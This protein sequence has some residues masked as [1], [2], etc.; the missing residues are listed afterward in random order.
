MSLHQPSRRT[1]LRGAALWAAVTAAGFGPVK[2]ALA[3]PVF[4]ND[5]FQL[6][7]ASG[8]PV[9]D[10]FVI[11]TRLAPDPFDPQALPDEAIPVAW[12][13]A[14]DAAMKKI[15]ASGQVYARPDMAHSVHVDVRGLEPHRPYYYRFH[16]GAAVSRT[17]RA[18]TLPAPG[19]AVDR[20]RFAFASCANFEKGYFDAYRDIAAQ[21]P[22]FIL[23]LGDYIYETVSANPLRPHPAPEP[24]T[25]EGYRLYHAAYKLD[26]DLQAA[27][28]HCPWFFTWDDHEVANDYTKDESPATRDPA[29]F[30]ARKLA[31][32]K[33][34]Y[35]HLPLRL[36]ALSNG[37]P[38]RLYQRV[39]YG[40]LAEFN[41]TDGRQYR[42]RLP[43]TRPEWPG[44]RM[45]DVTACVDYDDPR[46]S[47]LGT[48]QEAWLNEGFARSGVRWNVLAHAQM[49]TAFDQIPGPPRGV[50]TDSWSGYPAARRR[51]LDM[52]QV[53]KVPNVISLAGDIHSFFVADVKADDFAKGAPALM[54][55]FVG[56]SITS[57]SFNP[58]LY[59][60]LMADNPSFKFCNGWHRGYALCDVGKDGWRVDLRAVKDVRERGSAVT[61]LKSFIVENGKAGAQNA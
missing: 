27:H 5:P 36:P 26:P 2:R 40:D 34:Y 17:G 49:F 29:A 46:R 21:D 43:C 14:V 24:T 35:E 28:A 33:A 59:E 18:V 3:A 23:H 16:S 38:A 7:I 48:A 25:L 45:I 53:R 19:A 1:L 56:T 44:G 58:R 47:L 4:L 10:G 60:T 39:L 41:I 61:T 51:L 57:E 42:D 13:V 12:E 6:G 20:L 50:F 11:W 9:A 31:A 8:D 15:V 32:Y 54:S 37:G 52:V 30:T 55:E 22:A